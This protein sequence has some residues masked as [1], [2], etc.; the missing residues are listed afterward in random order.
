VLG[1][2]RSVTEPAR[3]SA[4]QKME[5]WSSGSC[6]LLPARAANRFSESVS[7]WLAAASEGMKSNKRLRDLA[8]SNEYHEERGRYLQWIADVFSWKIR[9]YT[10]LEKLPKF[11][12][13]PGFLDILTEFADVDSIP[14]DTSEELLQAAALQL[15]HP[16]EI[17]CTL[18]ERACV[19]SLLEALQFVFPKAGVGDSDTE[20][21]RRALYTRLTG[22]LA[23]TRLVSKNGQLIDN[24]GNVE[25]LEFYPQ[26]V[27]EAI[28]NGNAQP[29]EVRFLERLHQLYPVS[30]GIT[31]H[32]ALVLA[33]SRNLVEAKKVA[34][35]G[36]ATAFHDSSRKDC[37]DLLDQIQQAGG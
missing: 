27:Q 17:I 4:R 11:T 31:F 3:E 21:Q 34:A 22:E 30:G 6:Q 9:L 24:P 15:G 2:T 25:I 26:R 33:H 32:Y 7:S 20:P 10:F 12:G 13:Q 37:K 8:G 29:D 14:L 18:V 23:D 35:R 36:V 1:V 16:P 19:G 5:T 28:R